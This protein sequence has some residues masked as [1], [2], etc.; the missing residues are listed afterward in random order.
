[1]PTPKK[2]K[3]TS[4]SGTKKKRVSTTP[5]NTPQPPT[6]N[7]T[8]TLLQTN[9]TLSSTLSTDPLELSIHQVGVPFMKLVL[10]LPRQAS[11][12]RLQR[13]IAERLHGGGVF[14]GD[15]VLFEKMPAAVREGGMEGGESLGSLDGVDGGGLVGFGRADAMKMR[16]G[17][18]RLDA[19]AQKTVGDGSTP[20][21]SNVV[22]AETGMI[23]SSLSIATP[24]TTTASTHPPFGSTTRINIPTRPR[25]APTSKDSSASPKNAFGLVKP[26]KPNLHSNILRDP[27]LTLSEAFPPPQPLPLPTPEPPSQPSPHHHLSTPP[28]TLPLQPPKNPHTT[29]VNPASTQN[30]NTRTIWYDIHTY[31]TPARPST[32]LG[33]SSSWKRAGENPYIPSSGRVVPHRF[34]RGGWVMEEVGGWGSGGLGGCW[35]SRKARRGEDAAKKKATGKVGKGLELKEEVEEE[36]EEVEDEMV[37][38]GGPASAFSNSGGVLQTLTKPF[39]GA[40]GTP[41]A[42]RK[43]KGKASSTRT[44]RK[45]SLATPASSTSK[46]K[47]PT[48]K[49]KFM[50]KGQTPAS[51]VSEIRYEP[52]PSLLSAGSPPPEAYLPPSRDP[53]G[54]VKS[55]LGIWEGLVQRGRGWSRDREEDRKKGG[56]G[57]KL[58]KKKGGKGG[59][60]VKSGGGGAGASKKKG[61]GKKTTKS[62]V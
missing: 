2:K 38:G 28:T 36:E 7:P 45:M 22:D 46:G 4:T 48:K 37:L 60:K 23:T 27:Y 1:M 11:L 24:T 55:V 57:K 49:P 34:E 20:I 42:A 62:V 56:K 39:D 41:S 50:K 18:K 12:Y 25:T 6:T 15:V 8:L 16:L 52:P 35:V 43:L 31:T 10:T 14:A 40:V 44:R 21:V 54:V 19:S 17:T 13:E 53:V 58:G 32:S 47:K 9:P 29:P 30:P 51:I 26:H 3:R 59:G 61:A 5:K 33:L